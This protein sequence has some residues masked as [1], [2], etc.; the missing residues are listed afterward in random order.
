MSEIATNYYMPDSAFIAQTKDDAESRM[1]EIAVAGA[2]SGKPLTEEEKM[3]LG[4]YVRAV[5]NAYS[6]TAARRH[7]GTTNS[8][9]GSIIGF[10]LDHNAKFFR[11]V[12]NP[13]TLRVLPE[14]ASLDDSEVAKC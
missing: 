6:A 8:H 3:E 9:S 7:S 14:T 12:V 5:I 10:D 13:K 4:E 2:Q 11:D 1:H